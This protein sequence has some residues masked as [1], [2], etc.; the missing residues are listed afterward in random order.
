MKI[1]YATTYD[2]QDKSNWSGLGYYISRCLRGNEIDVEYL[3]APRSPYEAVGIARKLVARASGK[4][5]YAK[6]ET[7][8]LKHQARAIARQAEQT[9]VDAIFSPGTLPIAYLETD[10]PICL[11]TDATFEAMQDYYPEFIELSRAAITAGHAADQAAFGKAALCAFCCDWAAQSA[12]DAYGLDPDRVA[13]LP[14]GANMEKLPS[15][16]DVMAAIAARP[17]D[18]F[19]LLFIGVDWSRK[20][21]DIA[22][23][24]TERLNALGYPTRLTV[25]GA[26]P[27]EAAMRSGVVDYV[28]WIRKREPEGEKQLA[29]LFS[30]AHALILPT[31]AECFGVVMVE[32]AAFGAPSIVTRT[33]GTPSA[34]KEGVS[35]EL[36]PLEAG[37]EAFAAALA[38]L[39]ADR[40]AYEKRASAAFEH[41]WAELDWG[42]NGAR[43]RSRLE[44]VVEKH[45]SVSARSTKAA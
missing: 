9:D 13:I 8:V 31:Q 40:D 44:D 35:G 43:F 36:I 33:G 37:G 22:V 14:F 34:V 17:R 38:A 29:E 27:P 45:K 2:A 7:L 30:R 10:K 12:I 5:F 11:W 32:A 18:R 15:E 41:Y 39:F 6:R 21:G 20:G 24:A 25:V 23:E 16:S 1:G 28:G 19:E 4:A 3:Q 42:V 26:E